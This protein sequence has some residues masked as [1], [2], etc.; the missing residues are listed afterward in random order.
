MSRLV[1]IEKCAQNWSLDP[2]GD[3]F[4]AAEMLQCKCMETDL[5]I[6]DLN[7]EKSVCHVFSCLPVILTH[8]LLLP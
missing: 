7:G 2:S 6:C 4:Q 8:L 1:L 5:V 3:F